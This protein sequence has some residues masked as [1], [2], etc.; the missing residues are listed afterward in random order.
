MVAT[1]ND[2]WT[3]SIT[4]AMQSWSQQTKRGPVPVTAHT[5]GFSDQAIINQKRTN[6]KAILTQHRLDFEHY[7][8]NDT[9]EL[10]KHQETAGRH[11]TVFP[12]H[13]WFKHANT[14][15]L[16]LVSIQH[17]KPRKLRRRSAVL[18][19][20]RLR[21]LRIM[22]PYRKRAVVG[23]C[24][25]QTTLYDL[26]CGR[27]ILQF[28]I[29]NGCVQYE[30][31]ANATAFEKKINTILQSTWHSSTVLF[32]FSAIFFQALA[33]CILLRKPFW[34]LYKMGYSRIVL[35]SELSDSEFISLVS[36]LAICSHASAIIAVCVLNCGIPYIALWDTMH[37]IVGYNIARSSATIHPD[38]ILRQP[39]AGTAQVCDGLRWCCAS[40]STSQV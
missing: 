35:R 38:G 25:G 1:Q 12:V 40:V 4:P 36:K 33:F 30:K 13:R 34:D 10:T 21:A 27:Q 23:G 8:L 2:W 39:C 11:C 37:C 26:C 7:G 14:A 20:N 17:R 5:H 16:S 3:N 24:V 6:Q 18:S 29:Q 9:T 31:I 22:F 15:L 32:I 28:A 19:C